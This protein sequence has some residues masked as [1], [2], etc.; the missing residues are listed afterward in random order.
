MFQPTIV[1]FK[2][3][4]GAP[5][6]CFLP[7]PQ[8]SLGGKHGKPLHEPCDVMLLQDTPSKNKD[9]TW[10]HPGFSSIEKK[11]AFYE[12]FA[13]HYRTILFSFK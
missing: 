5:Y 12:I 13:V 6:T 3:A 1:C 11:V 10:D 2:F 7:E 8:R 9:A 4:D